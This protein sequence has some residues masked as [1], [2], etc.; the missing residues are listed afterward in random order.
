MWSYCN[1]T[2]DLYHADGA[3]FLTNGHWPGANIGVNGGITESDYTYA[4]SVERDA[5]IFGGEIYSGWFTHFNDANWAEKPLNQFLS[6]FNFLL[7]HNHS[8]SMYMVHGGTN[9]GTSAGANGNYLPYVT[10]YDYS[11]PISEQGSMNDKFIPFREMVRKYVDWVIPEPP[12]SIPMIVIPSFKP[13]P[14]ANLFGNLPEAA[15]K[16]SPKAYVF[17]SA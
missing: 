8:F 15:I 5:Y 11:A 13:V 6:E 3:S 12:A 16:Q 4:R 7:T 14:V 2:C 9:F 1:I 10:S 17:E